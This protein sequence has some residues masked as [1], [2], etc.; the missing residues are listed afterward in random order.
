MNDHILVEAGR[1]HRHRRVQP[2]EDAQRDQLAM[3]SEIAW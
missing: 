1:A 2:A 3:W